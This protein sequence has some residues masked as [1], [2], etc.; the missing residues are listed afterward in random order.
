MITTIEGCAKGIVKVVGMCYVTRNLKLDSNTLNIVNE[1]KH[2][3]TIAL[4]NGNP[5]T[6]I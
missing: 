1:E 3:G 5:A 6:E 2:D 4:V